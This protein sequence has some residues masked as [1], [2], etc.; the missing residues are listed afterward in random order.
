MASV[1]EKTIRKAVTPAIQAVST[2]NRARLP[3]A[4]K[5][6]FLRGVPSPLAEEFTLEGLE[7]TGAIPPQLDGR[8]VRIGPNPYG[9]G[10]KGHHWFV[11]DGMVHGVRLQNGKADWYRNRYIRS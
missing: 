4:D 3:G 8:Y 9:N 11:G 10:T 7:V 5:N 2:I 1:I 6:P